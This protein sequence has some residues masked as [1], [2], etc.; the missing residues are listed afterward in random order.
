MPSLKLKRFAYILPLTLLGAG[1]FVAFSGLEMSP[2][3]KDQ[4]VLLPVQIGALV[5]FLWWRRER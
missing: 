3:L 4:L 1:Y 5:Y 2:L